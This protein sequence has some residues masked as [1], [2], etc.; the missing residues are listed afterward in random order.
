MQKYLVSS[1]ETSKDCLKKQQANVRTTRPKIKLEGKV[2]SDDDFANTIP[3][4]TPNSNGI[5]DSHSL[6]NVFWC[7]V[8]GDAITG[9]FYTDMTGA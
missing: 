3:T 6:S 4:N 8:L 9:T 2:Q 1:P 5:E 7:A